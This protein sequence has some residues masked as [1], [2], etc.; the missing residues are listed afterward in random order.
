[1]RVVSISDWI[2]V[3]GSSIHNKGVFAAKDIPKGTKVI[4]YVGRKVTKKESDRISERDLEANSKDKS[5]GAVYLF[6]LNKRYDLDGNV[7]WNTARFINHSCN[8][9]CE[10]E[11]IKGKI[12]IVSLRDIKKG[13]ELNYDYGYDMD[14]YEDHPCK[15]GSNE[16]IGYIVGTEHRKKL[17]RKLEKEKSNE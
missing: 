3:R 2:E 15:C 11:I 17:K 10:T 9:N 13:E 12:W 8:P 4:E 6:E 16:C 7:P 14:T 5:N 1:M